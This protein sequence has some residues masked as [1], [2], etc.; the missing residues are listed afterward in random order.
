M[1]TRTYRF[2]V[3]LALCLVLNAGIVSTVSAFGKGAVGPD[4]YAVQAMLKSLGYYPGGIDGIYGTQTVN[5]VRLFQRTYGLTITGAVNDQTLKSLLWAYEVAKIP[6]VKP[7]RTEPQPSIPKQ[8]GVP[9]LSADEQQMVNL[10]NAARTKEGLTALKVN[11]ELSRV[12]R[13]KSQ[14]MIDNNYF[15]HQSPAYGSPFEMMKNFGITY[16]SAGENIACNQSVEAAHE[17]LMNS[18]GHRANIMNKGFTEIGIG[19]VN[20]GMC[21]QMFTQHFIGR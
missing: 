5:G 10:V 18:P 2:V 15:S 9:Q 4:V 20:G 7:P 14:D 13:F 19:I 17:A 6:A 21:G 8:T 16:S 11:L 3:I 1:S 12:A